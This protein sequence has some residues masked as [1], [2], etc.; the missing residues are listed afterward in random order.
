MPTQKIVK[1]D[2]RHHYKSIEIQDQDMSDDRS[3]PLSPSMTNN[4]H[5]MPTIISDPNSFGLADR[6]IVNLDDF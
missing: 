3:I 2:N 6:I 1:E 5:T 4:P